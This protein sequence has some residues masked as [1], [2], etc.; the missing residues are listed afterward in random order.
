MAKRCA[1][2]SVEEINAKKAN[3]VPKN[4]TKTNY[5]AARLL[6]IY[7]EDLKEDSNFEKY[8]IQE[9]TKTLS[10]FYLDLRTQRGELH[11]ASSLE[12]GFTGDTS[13]HSRI[14]C[15]VP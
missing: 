14:P 12:Q 3:L 2:Y 13:S 7:L 15:E 11:K 6:R 5:R 9:L 1:L 8:N 4:A 10:H